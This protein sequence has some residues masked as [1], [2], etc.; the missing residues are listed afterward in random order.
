MTM[1]FRLVDIAINKYNFDVDKIARG[2]SMCKDVIMQ[3]IDK[4]SNYRKQLNKLKEIPIIKQK[5]PEWYEARNSM[6]S[7]SD[8]AQSIGLGKFGTQKDLIKKKCDDAPAEFSASNPFFK[9]GN[10]FESVA[11]NI[12]SILNE[13]IQMNEFGLL[14]HPKHNFFGASPDSISDNG[15]LCEI[16]CPL[17]RKITGE[18]PTQY[19][20]QI[21]G[22]LEVCG[23]EECDYFECEFLQENNEKCFLDNNQY[24]FKGVIVEQED[25]TMVYSDIFHQNQSCHALGRFIKSY[26]EASSKNKVLM[27]YLKKYMIKRVFRDEKLFNEKIKEVEEVW[28]KILFYRKNKDQYILDIMSTIDILDTE[29]CYP[30][31]I[32]KS[33]PIKG[34]AFQDV[35]DN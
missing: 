22:Q 27:W 10:M 29:E 35:D 30:K 15:I 26:R 14:K 24:E 25:G 7:A 18:I 17:K 6:I 2:T 31:E 19:Y 4:L 16:K 33:S 12:Y 11:V 3:R 32:K 20:L 21:L 8:M 5:S 1:E 34:Y 13:G 28:N 23:L 9:W